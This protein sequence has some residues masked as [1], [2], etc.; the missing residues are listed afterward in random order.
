VKF[1]HDSQKVLGIILHNIQNVGLT[2]K[3]CLI[4]CGINTSFLTDWKSNKIKTPSYDKIVKLS[5]FLNID[6]NQLLLGSRFEQT[7]EEKILLK[8][9]NELKPMQK[10]IILGKAEA[11]YESTIAEKAKLNSKQIKKRLPAPPQEV[12]D[13]IDNTDFSKYGVV[14]LYI[15]E[16]D[17]PVSAG[18]GVFLEEVQA[19][20]IFVEPSDEVKHADYVLRIKG[21]SMKPI[22]YDGDRVFIQETDAVDVGEVGIFVYEGE[23]FIKKLGEGE[24]LSFNQKYPPIRIIEHERFYCK[25]RVLGKVEI[26]KE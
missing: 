14:G 5:R 19:E 6:L 8:Y 9:F 12:I 3:E 15:R 20:P 18:D 16:Y 17:M 1:V 24:L 11:F 10:G 21:D 13:V 2:E 22:Y 26:I 23:A 25:G 7:E 4:S